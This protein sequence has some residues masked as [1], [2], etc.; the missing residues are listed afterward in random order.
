MLKQ[1]QIG[2]ACITALCLFCVAILWPIS[3]PQQGTTSSI[4]IRLSSR[5]AQLRDDGP[6]SFAYVLYATS[7]IYLCN[8]VI[9]ARRLKNLKVTPDADIVVLTDR[10]FLEDS[11]E[12][13]LAVAKRI[14][15]LRALEV[16]NIALPSC[17][18]ST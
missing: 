14:N 5:R 13:S 12:I 4:S 1:S 16:R 8:A 17:L 7:E 3:R 2:L 6:P 9:N 11:N 15:I 10:A 18:W